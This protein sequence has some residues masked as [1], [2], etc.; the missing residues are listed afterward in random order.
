MRAQIWE[1]IGKHKRRTHMKAHK[2]AYTW[3]WAAWACQKSHFVWKFRGKCQAPSPQEQVCIEVR[4]ES[5]GPRARAHDCVAIYR[6]THMDMSRAILCGNFQEKWRT[7]FPGS[8]STA[9]LSHRMLYTQVNSTQE[10]TGC[11]FGFA[12]FSKVPECPFHDSMVL[13]CNNIRSYKSRAG[14]R[15]SN[16]PLPQIL[17]GQKVRIGNYMRPDPWQNREGSIHHPS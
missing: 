14:K 10:S 4:R 15:Q 3:T 16:H 6:N 9:D 12:S 2:K 5:P 11:V 17:W 7:P 8:I 1:H 13:R